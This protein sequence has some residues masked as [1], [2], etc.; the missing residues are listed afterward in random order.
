MPRTRQRDLARLACRGNEG[1]RGQGLARP[2]E[3]CHGQGHQAVAA[4]RLPL[5]RTP[6]ALHDA[7]HGDRP[8]QNR[9][10]PGARD[11]GGCTGRSIPE[12]GTT[13]FRPPYTPVAIGAFAGR[14]A[15]ATFRPMRQ[16][17]GH[18]WAEEKG[19]V[20][21][22]AGLWLRAQ[23]F[24]REG[25][26]ELARQ[27]RPRGAA[28][29]KSVGICDVTTLGKIDIQGRDAAEFLNRVYSNGFAKLPSASALRADAAR[30]RH[31]HGRRHDRASRRKPFRHDHDDG[32][33]RLRHSAISNSAA[34][35]CGRD[36]T[37]T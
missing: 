10:C 8:G 5:G 28:T 3:R 9:Q 20:F 2:P 36:S 22:E 17:P 12:T 4:G 13:I 32:Q 11:D 35:A 26:N 18:G 31:G 33:R 34:S 16:T 23:W 1:Q 21:V 24:R 37:S 7:R 29:R 25:E 19:G 6:Q 30:G 15:A 14:R 27:R